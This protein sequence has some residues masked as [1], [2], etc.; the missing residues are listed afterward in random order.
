MCGIIGWVDWERNLSEQRAMVQGMAESLQL[1]GPD[2]SGLWLSPRAALA[3]RRLFVI[4]PH[5]GVQPMTRRAGERSYTLVFNGEIYNFRDLSRDLRALGHTFET[6]SDTEVL[7]RAYMEWGP[8]CL[9]RLNG[10]FA[11]AVWDETRQ[12]LFLARD[13]LG[14]KPLF[15]AERG[16]ALLFAS[17][18]K[19]LFKNPLVKRE[20]GAEGL[21]QALTVGFVR[22][23]GSSVYRGIQEIRP[24]HFAVY[25]RNGL[26]ISRYWKL[27]SREH[28]DDAETTLRRVRGMLEDVVTRQM[29]T[30]MNV[31][32]MLS[33]GL[34]S[35]GVTAIAAKEYRATKNS[36]LDTFTVD[37]V[38]EARH[39]RAD[40][41]HRDLD[42][43]WARRVSELC[44]TNHR[45]VTLGAEDL[46]GHIHAPLTARDLPVSGEKE[47]SAL[48]L[49]RKMKEAGAT[50]VLSGEAGDEIFGGHPWFYV[51][52]ILN[53]N[54]FPWLA[55]AQNLGV[56]LLAPDIAKKVRAEE[57]LADTYQSTLNEVPKL[58]GESP[59][60]ARVREMFYLNINHFLRYML[61]RMDRI[62]MA[63]SLEVRVPLC[64]HQL[65]EYMWN[66][67]PAMKFAGNVEK[68]LLRQAMSHLLP[69]DVI[70]RRKTAYPSLHDPSY[71]K[72]IRARVA[73]IVNDNQSPVHGLLDREAVRRLTTEEVSPDHPFGAAVLKTRLDLVIQL[74]HWLKD[75][76]V[77]L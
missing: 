57:Y 34:D 71:V 58:P 76:P 41:M 20:L 16:G 37:F 63:A 42:T 60:D 36:A 13:H 12:E 24:G 49:F 14:V 17:E 68:G 9:E 48:L 1:R 53:M 62:S 18:E 11:F 6:R 47:I 45:T 35:S 3:H 55:H 59:H 7:L 19:A 2:D 65:V 39:F 5:G 46:L 43:P 74:D 40:L 61:D 50:V 69:E 32:S 8:S 38:D 26:K 67:P 10:I 77:V 31:C 33:G 66:V 56:P 30:D 64:D 21:A 25:S 22:T 75:C 73:D 51:P 29:V 44:G 27:E 70:A 4:D 52:Q 23:Q 72:G 15:Y 54:A 28:T